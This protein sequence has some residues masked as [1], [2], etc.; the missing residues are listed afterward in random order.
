MMACVYHVV[1]SRKPPD[2]LHHSC[3]CTPGVFVA[4]HVRDPSLPLCLHLSTTQHQPRYQSDRT[5]RNRSGIHGA[6]DFHAVVEHHRF[7]SL[8]GALSVV[9]VFHC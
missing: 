1:E 7:G 9:W 8:S 3:P 4:T 2:P 6:T 5:R